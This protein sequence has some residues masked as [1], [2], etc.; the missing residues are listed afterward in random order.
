MSLEALLAAEA[1]KPGPYCTVARALA[2]MSKKDAATLVEAF[3]NNAHT[4]SA[5]ARAVNK[6]GLPFTIGLHAVTRHRK[7][8]CACGRR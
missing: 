2:T 3:S 7:G 4:T 1:N 6:L 5:I 8:E